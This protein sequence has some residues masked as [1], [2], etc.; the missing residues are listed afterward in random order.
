MSGRFDWN[1]PLWHTLLLS[2]AIG[3][4]V[5]IASRFLDV[6][7]VWRYDYPSAHNSTNAINHLNYGLNVTKGA[8]IRNGNP[9]V[10]EQLLISTHHPPLLSLTLAAS[11]AVFGVQEIVARGTVVFFSILNVLLLYWS[12]RLLIGKETAL[13]SAVIFAL[14][15]LQ[16]VYATKVNFEPMVLTFVLAVLVAYGYW[17]RRPGLSRF[18]P[19]AILFCIGTMM[20]WGAYY[21]GGILP[22]F[23]FVNRLYSRQPIRRADSM[24]WVLTGLGVAMFALFIG[25]LYWIDPYLVTELGDLAAA[26][27]GLHEDYGYEGAGFSTFSLLERTVTRSALLFTLPALALGFLGLLLAAAQLAGSPRGEQREAQFILLFLA[28]GIAHLAVFRHVYW[29]HEFL[30][31]TLMVPVAVSAGWLLAKLPRMLPPRVALAATLVFVLMFLPWSLVKTRQ[32]F[33]EG[34]IP[35]ILPLAEFLKETVPVGSVIFTNAIHHPFLHPGVPH[36]AERDV[37]NG[38]ETMSDLANRSTAWKNSPLYFMAFHAPSADPDAAREL[39]SLLTQRF[40]F[41]RT[42][43]GP[44]FDLS[45]P[46]V[47][48]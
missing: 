43:W 46:H 19:M 36:Y 3:I 32:K 6:P 8:L 10:P 30:V 25:H 17:L 33:W 26:R 44:I 24:L 28:L 18:L 42:Q 7:F 4:F 31:H 16:I 13:R 14:L 40:P 27:S 20:D 29:V 12:V 38:V 41:Q 45:V 23:H 21:I 2:A 37:I 15:P 22:V 11:Y 39:L 47:E 35:E 9:V 34:Q 48:P 1:G 5:L